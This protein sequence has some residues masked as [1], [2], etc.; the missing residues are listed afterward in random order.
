MPRRHWLMRDLLRGQ[1]ARRELDEEF[2]RRVQRAIDEARARRDLG[3]ERYGFQTKP[4][5]ESD[6]E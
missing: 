2:D 6:D 3:Y 4:K 1:R 5:R